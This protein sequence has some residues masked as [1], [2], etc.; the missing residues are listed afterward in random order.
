MATNKPAVGYEKH[1][2]S[3][4]DRKITQTPAQ[5]EKKAASIAPD[6]IPTGG[7]KLSGL[8]GLKNVA[9]SKQSGNRH[10]FGS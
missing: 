8:A 7:S 1:E 4:S 5:P 6:D 9:Q 10:L 2:A 3:G